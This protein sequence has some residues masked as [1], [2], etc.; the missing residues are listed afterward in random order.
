MWV[1]V[2]D[3]FLR[4]GLQD[5]HVVVPTAEKQRVFDALAAAGVPRIEAA[6]FVHPSKVPQMADAQELFA[7]LAANGAGPRATALALN[8]RGIRR[9]VE[10][11]VREVQVVAS[12]SRAHSSANAGRSTDEALADIAAEV[13]RHPET[14]FFAGISTAFTCP[15]EGRIA[16]EVLLAVV[17]RFATMGVRKVGLADTLGTTPTDEVLAALDCVRRAEP[18]LTYSLHLHN[19]HGQALATVTAAAADGIDRFDAA[20]AGFGGCPFAPGAAG[21]LATE[22]LV[23]HLHESGHRTGI[24]EARLG[25]AA[26]MARDAVVRAPALA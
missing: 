23:R 6:S 3:V 25:E 24:D 2:T 26:R 7:G 4:D 8:A 19:A 21:N 15:F 9:A 16:P 18:D 13:A 20:L 1:E 14:E 5:E 17:R 10:S 12:A 22:E 11:G